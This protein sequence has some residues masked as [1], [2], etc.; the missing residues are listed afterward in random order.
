MKTPIETDRCCKKSYHN[1]T[2]FQ[3]TWIIGP[4]FAVDGEPVFNALVWGEPLNSG[5]VSR[6][7]HFMV[8]CFKCISISGTV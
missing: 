4:T 7:Y 8:F 5:L 6:K 3:D 2:S 1:N